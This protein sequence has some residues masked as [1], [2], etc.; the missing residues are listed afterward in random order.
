[1]RVAIV[2]AGLMGRWHADAA[3]RAGA[4]IVAVVD[5]DIARATALAARCSRA[6]TAAEAYANLDAPI[7]R[8]PVDAVH[9]C[10]P[11]GTHAAVAR[12][13]LAGGAHVLVEKPLAGTAAETA[14]LLAAAAAVERMLIPVHQFSFQHGVRR[15]LRSAALGRVLHVDATICSAGAPADLPGDREQ[16]AADILPHPLSLAQLWLGP[17]VSHVRWHV[18]AAA[19][20]DWRLTGQS[21]ATTIGIL[22]SMGGRPT[23]NTLRLIGDRGSAH[24]DLFHDFAVVE[25]GHV[26]RFRKIVH[27]FQLAAATLGA[28]STNAVRRAVRRER[29]Y[30]G[31]RALVR[32]FYDAIRSG[33]A[34]PV[35]AEAIVDVARAR[36]SVRRLVREARAS[37]ARL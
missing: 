29:A 35:S 12:R 23:T 27:P 1:M 24:I 17:V 16:I 34:P 22:I 25:S 11:L 26:S 20:G 10:T 9:V 32:E 30:P 14:E 21:G 5:A 15:V 13:A 3:L 8:S 4:T 2:G 36:D 28:A 18:Q 33:G 31:L 37:D 7:S 6:S 19:D